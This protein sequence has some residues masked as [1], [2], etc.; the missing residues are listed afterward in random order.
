MDKIITQ[1]KC[2]NKKNKLTCKSKK[3]LK[4]KTRKKI[5]AHATLVS[6]IAHTQ[7]QRNYSTHIS[8]KKIAHLQKCICEHCK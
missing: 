3:T 7:I 6:M 2:K 4:K 5:T 8:C 1:C